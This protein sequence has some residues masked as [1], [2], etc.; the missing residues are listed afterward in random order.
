VDYFRYY[1]LDLPVTHHF[2]TF[3]SEDFTLA[4]HLFVPDAARGTVFLLHGY[5]DHSGV[6]TSI[7]RLCTEEHLA[8]AVFDLPGHGLASGPAASIDD[9]TQ[10]SIA[11]GNFLQLCRAR[12]PEPYH[13]LGHSMGGAVAID[14]LCRP[15]SHPFARTILL[16]PLVRCEHYRLARTAFVLLGRFVPR[17]PRWFRRS[18]SDA[19]FLRFHR[20]DPLACRHCPTPWSR[21]YHA[22]LDRISAREVLVPAATVIQGTRDAVVDWRYNVLFLQ[23]RIADLQVVLING[24]RHQ[25]MNEGEPYRTRFMGALRDQLASL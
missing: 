19:H 13:L 14:Y 4:A 1:G 12:A 21:A 22:W 16:A 15:G 5:Y 25:L 17:V 6:L 24:A 10:Y 23:R 2:G 3:Q 9:F 8:A 18:S 20:S 7:I 11:L